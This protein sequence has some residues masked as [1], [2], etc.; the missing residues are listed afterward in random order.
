M[1]F[2]IFCGLLFGLAAAARA[3]GVGTAT[4]DTTGLMVPWKKVPAPIVKARGSGVHSWFFGACRLRPN[5][6]TYVHFYAYPIKGKSVT[7]K[8]AGAWSYFIDFYRRTS[9]GAW[10]RWRHIPNK[11]NYQEIGGAAVELFWLDSKKSVPVFVTNF[12]LDGFYGTDNMS[13]LFTFSK[14]VSQLP[15][16]Q[17]F[18]AQGDHNFSYWPRLNSRDAHGSLQVVIEENFNG[19][20]GIFQNRI[21][22]WNGHK[23]ALFG[24][25][26]NF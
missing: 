4:R 13:R 5:A 3:D 15:I 25:P 10:Q 12:F 19:G 21:Y 14:G 26:R 9:R 2:L 23:F 17:D 18:G 11:A 8:G 22:R 24:K 7:D 20:Q 6:V 1:K 16:I